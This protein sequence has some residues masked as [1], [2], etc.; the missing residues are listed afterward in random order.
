METWRVR[1]DGS[2]AERLLPD[3]EDFQTTA[4]DPDGASDGARIVLA[5]AGMIAFYDLATRTVRS[6]GIPG[7]FPRISPSGDAIVY[8]NIESG[9][10]SPLYIVRSDGTGARQLTPGRRYARF[11][12]YT[13]SSDGEWIVIRGQAGL[14]LIRAATGE[15]MPLPWSAR[16]WEPAFH[17]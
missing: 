1:V 11:A 12:G 17:P 2:G 8:S 14:E 3:P 4:W 9:L 7:E 13:W 10:V 5:Y 6:L 16:M 15:V